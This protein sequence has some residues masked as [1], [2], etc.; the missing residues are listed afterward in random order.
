MLHTDYESKH[1]VKKNN[2]GRESRGACR[3]DELID[4]KPPVVMCNNISSV[5]VG[6]CWL[7][8]GK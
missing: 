7:G 1:S 3:E 6:Y 8:V 4:G 2:A 5:V